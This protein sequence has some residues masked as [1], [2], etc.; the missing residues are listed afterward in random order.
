MFDNN[1][2]RAYYKELLTLTLLVLGQSQ[3]SSI[4]APGV[5]SKARWMAIATYTLKIFIFQKQ[6]TFAQTVKAKLFH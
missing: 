6:L 4:K 1:Q 2:P 3:S 5:N